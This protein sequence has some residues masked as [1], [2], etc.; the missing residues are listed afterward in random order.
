MLPE[1]ALYLGSWPRGLSGSTYGSV[2]LLP[3]PYCGRGTGHDATLFSLLLG[4]C[5]RLLDT[6]DFFLIT[7][8]GV[9]RL[10]SPKIT[11]LD[12]PED[13]LLSEGCL[14]RCNTCC[15]HV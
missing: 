13:S 3:F 1:L 7:G 2:S 10:G 6:K 12:T 4:A 14:E 8:L 11:L 15:H 5:R 9:F